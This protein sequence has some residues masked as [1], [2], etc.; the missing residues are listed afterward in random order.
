M[1]TTH[2]WRLATILF[3]SC[4]HI[5]PAGAIEIGTRVDP[6]LKV[7]EIEHL[8]HESCC[9]HDLA[10]SEFDLQKVEEYK[11]RFPGSAKALR[12]LQG[13]TYA[14]YSPYQYPWMTFNYFILIWFTSSAIY[15]YLEKYK[16]R[17]DIKM[18]IASL[19]EDKKRNIVTYAV[20]ILG[21]SFSLFAQ[22]YGGIDIVFL[23]K[24]ETT[25]YRVDWMVLCII[26]IAVIYTWELIYRL[27]IGLPLL[28]HH[29]ITIIFCQLSMASFFDTGNILF[30]RCATIVGF[31]AT[32]EQMTFV[33]L[34]FYRLDIYRQYHSFLFY[35][36]AALS[37]II[38]SIVATVAMWQYAIRIQNDEEF[39]NWETFWCYTFVPL[40]LLLYGTQIYACRILYLLGSRCR[41][42]DEKTDIPTN[43]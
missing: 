17:A 31:H 4:L 36:A 3:L 43:V 20:Q 15:L 39:D 29:I 12:Y 42:R 22:I 34:L 35:F 18:V 9:L 37:F 38:K 21:S 10:A 1:T 24:D 30:L 26:S 11:Q 41:R 23:L 8:L 27:K 40:L 33:A 6:R 32:T 7:D 25:Q 28:I 2:H 14:T 19:S 13:N 16:G 5:A